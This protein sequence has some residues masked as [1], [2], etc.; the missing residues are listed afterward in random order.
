MWPS[1]APQHR[2]DTEYARWSLVCGTF[3]AM[4]EADIKGSSTKQHGVDTLQEDR[5][6][7]ISRNCQRKYIGMGILVNKLPWPHSLHHP[8]LLYSCVLSQSTPP[9]YR[10][11]SL[12]SLHC[13]SC[14]STGAARGACAGRIDSGCYILPAVP[15][16]LAKTCATQSSSYYDIIHEKEAL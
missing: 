14:I 9:P 2:M 3:V 5:R 11:C 7:K 12:S 10:H 13:C 15:A 16:V 1:K 6:F 8:P 4:A